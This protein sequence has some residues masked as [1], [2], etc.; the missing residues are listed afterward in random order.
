MTLE[1]DVHPATDEAEARRVVFF[2]SYGDLGM[3]D[4]QPY[5]NFSEI[6]DT[7]LSPKIMGLIAANNGLKLTPHGLRVSSYPI[8]HF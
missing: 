6:A 3:V 1:V 2:N 7:K 5:A 4:S 8:T